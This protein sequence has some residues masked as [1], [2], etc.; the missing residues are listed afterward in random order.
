MKADLIA[1][2]VYFGFIILLI[3]YYFATRKRITDFFIIRGNRKKRLY[4]SL[5]WE[6]KR[7]VKRLRRIIENKAIEDK[8]NFAGFF[9][10]KRLKELLKALPSGQRFFT[11]THLIKLLQRAE[12]EGRITYQ[13]KY[14]CTRLLME[15]FAILKAKDILQILLS[16]KYRKRLFKKFYKVELTVK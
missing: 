2:A 7:K 9:L 4:Q 12:E 1:I 15:A 11:K 3:I 8:L 13:A 14:Y 6:G 10:Y 16:S 5:S